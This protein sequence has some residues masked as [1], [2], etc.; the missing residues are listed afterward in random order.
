MDK[1]YFVIPLSF[2][3]N[4]FIGITILKIAISICG[5]KKH[6]FFDACA[7][8]ASMGITA[9]LVAQ[10]PNAIKARCYNNQPIYIN[11][12]SYSVPVNTIKTMLSLQRGIIPFTTSLTLGTL[13]QT[14]LKQL[15]EQYV[16]NAPNQPI[17]ARQELFSVMAAGMLSAAFV[18]PA[19]YYMLKQ[20]NSS[21]NFFTVVKTSS[22]KN[23]FRSLGITGV[24]EIFSAGFLFS[25]TAAELVNLPTENKLL[26]SLGGSI[27]VA[28]VT[29]TLS[30]PVDKV[31]TVAQT[32]DINA[33]QAFNY[34]YSQSGWRGFAKGKDIFWR[35]MVYITAI[36]VMS[37][38]QLAMKR[39]NA[40]HQPL[41]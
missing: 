35:N 28:V 18:C 40:D 31:K 4:V 30:S 8:G 12:T 13:T 3:R 14:P 6:S 27:P 25:K 22:L 7:E 32:R 39:K 33:R 21:N 10:T 9:G 5:E 41:N 23:V 16:C 37:F 34:V 15:C 11:N 1:T 29:A 19:D 38:T 17:S 20:Q 36:P 24:R 2:I 26:Y